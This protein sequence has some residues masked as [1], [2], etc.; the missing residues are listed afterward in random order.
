MDFSIKD[1]VDFV[2]SNFNGGEDVILMFSF[3]LSDI[4]CQQ[5]TDNG[6][7]F[8]IVDSMY[9]NENTVYITP[10]K[11]NREIAILFDNG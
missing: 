1:L 7:K 4:Q 6:I 3:K 11:K 10:M 5:L 2:N 9:A 8:R